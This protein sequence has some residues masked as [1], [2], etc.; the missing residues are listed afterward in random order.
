MDYNQNDMTSGTQPYVQNSNGDYNQAYQQGYQQG[1]QAAISRNGDKEEPVTIGDWI[2]TYLL[3]CIPCVGVIL[4]F[5]W[6]FG[7][8]TKKS[9]SNYFK[10]QLI[11]T[12]I[13]LA[14]YVVLWVVLF[15]VMGISMSE[16]G[17][18]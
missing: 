7:S 9:K 12:A 11:I 6:A 5:V 1:Y 15:A 16:M 14:L 3:L 17:N 13:I 18:A 4:M 2:V 10:A 8:G